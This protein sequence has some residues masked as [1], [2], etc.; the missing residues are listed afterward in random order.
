MGP[1]KFEVLNRFNYVADLLLSFSEIKQLGKYVSDD[2]LCPIQ[3]IPFCIVS[4]CFH[5]R[6]SS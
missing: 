6:F 2:A 5:F 1:T 4:P 3:F